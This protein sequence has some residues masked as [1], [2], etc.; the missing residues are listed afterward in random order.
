MIE[1]DVGFEVRPETIELNLDH[2]GYVTFE[3]RT[4]RPSRGVISAAF[5]PH[6]ITAV[7]NP[8]ETYARPEE[9]LLWGDLHQHSN[10]SDGLGTPRDNY[11]F[12]RDVARLDFC[13]LSDH[14][15]WPHH[16]TEGDWRALCAAARECNQPGRFVTF[17]GYEWDASRYG[18][19]HMNVYYLNDGQPVFTSEDPHSN[20]PEKLFACLRDKNA[21][22][23]VHHPAAT[24]GGWFTTDWDHFNP[25]LEKLIEIYS[26][27]GSSECSRRD[28]NTHPIGRLGGLADH[29]GGCFVRD[30][31]NRGYRTG[32]IAGGDGHDGRPGRSA[33]FRVEDEEDSNAYTCGHR[34]YYP[35]GLQ[36][37]WATACTRE[38]IWQ[39]LHRRCT[40]AT[41][42]HRPIVRFTIN[43][44]PMGSEIELSRGKPVEIDIRY[45]GTDRVDRTVVFRNGRPF[46]SAR[47][48]NTSH[49]FAIAATPELDTDYFYS[50]ILQCDGNVTWTSP[51][52]VT[53]C[54]S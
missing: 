12:A 30:A 3:F 51:V 25:Q 21:L 31:L 8:V 22:V 34:P 33:L 39:A 44:E 27:W 5:R 18:Y 37:V 43:G 45:E 13:A 28:G 14:D 17:L 40:Y 15:I 48:T 29:G 46:R 10:M 32:L 53:W 47:G 20:T 1:A 23:I 36:G 2:S 7:S 54:G 42:G 49:A 19:G 26:I 35:S 52:W 11:A 6:G 4:M 9:M 41:T 50:R 38:A 24:R 16:F